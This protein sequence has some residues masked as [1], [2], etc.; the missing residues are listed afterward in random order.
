MRG[1]GQSKTWKYSYRSEEKQRRRMLEVNPAK[2]GAG[3]RLFPFYCMDALEC[4]ISKLECG[5][6]A[7]RVV[8]TATPPLRRKVRV[9]RGTFNSARQISRGQLCR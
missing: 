7:H 8:T 9:L 1:G 3:I 5:N 2:Q 4:V 6:K